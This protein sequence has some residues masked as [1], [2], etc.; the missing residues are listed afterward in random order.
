MRV[1]LVCP[2]AWD[3]PGG[4]RSHV[5]DLAVALQAHG[6][7]V[8]VLAPVE[9]AETLPPWVVDGGRPIAVRYNGSIARLSMGVSATRKVRGWIR[10]GDFDVLHVHEPVAPSLSLLA[11]WAARGPIVATW[12]SSHDRSRIL[13]AGYAVAQTAMEKV[14][15]RI[16]VSE[17]AR[18]TLVTHVGGDAVLIPNGVRVSAFASR[19]RLPGVDPARPALL[20][21]G[22]VDEPRKGLAVL[23]ASLPTIVAAVPD[24]QVLIA[25]PGSAD[26]SLAELPEEVRARITVLGR[27][28][29]E[30][31]VRALRS[32]DVYVAPHTGGESFGIVLVEA[33]AAQAAV[34]ASDLPA[35]RRV[36]DDGACGMLFPN[37]DEQGLAD[38]VV[39]ALG[40]AGLRA[41]MVAAGDAR[42]RIFDWDRVVDDVIAVYDSVRLPE[43]KVTEDLRG[44]IVGRLSRSGRGGGG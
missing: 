1:G 41:R 6:H 33:L 27:I 25:G 35:F 31:K 36:L 21:L 34:V 32:V 29:D 16:A 38:Q 9:D 3:V 2:Y 28:S 37:Q 18:R 30:D 17:E 42:V 13:S 5:A 12:H 11:L 24:V 10:S 26:D 4:V 7:D 44:Q 22:R 19:E 15:G 39:L 14:R 8:S 40:D 43:E 23:L 20:F